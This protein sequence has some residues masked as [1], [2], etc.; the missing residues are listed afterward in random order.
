MWQGFI[1]QNNFVYLPRPLLLFSF[2]LSVFLLLLLGFFSLSFFYFYCFIH[3]YK[4]HP[5]WKYKIQKKHPASVTGHYQILLF[6]ILQ[7]VFSISITDH[8]LDITRSKTAQADQSA[9]TK[10]WL[11]ELS[12]NHQGHTSWDHADHHFP[13]MRTRQKLELVKACFCD[14]ENPDNPLHEAMEDTKS[15]RL[16]WGKSWMGQAEESTL[17][18]C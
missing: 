13:L 15:S 4:F 12:G 5:E 10:L 18:A 9:K 8:A 16:G 2:F 17:Q 1:T 11:Q 14:V 7:N 3:N 6:T